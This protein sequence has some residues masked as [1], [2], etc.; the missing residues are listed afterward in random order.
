MSTT[1]KAD[2][3]RGK[4]AL[5]IAEVLNNCSILLQLEIENQINKIVLHVATDSATV[6]YVEVTK[7]GMLSFLSK[8]RE[9]VIRKDDIDDLLEEV[10]GRNK[11]WRK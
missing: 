2:Q 6:Q 3:S 10:Q 1:Y 9:Y 11:E 7:D 8:L 4:S 5:Q